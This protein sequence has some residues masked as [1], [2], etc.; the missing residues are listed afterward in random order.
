MGYMKLGQNRPGWYANPTDE[1]MPIGAHSTPDMAPD[2]RDTFWDWYAEN[3]EVVSDVA[4]D[5]MCL[6]F[7]NRCRQQ[8]PFGYPGPTPPPEKDYTLYLILG[9]V[10]ILLFVLILRKS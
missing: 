1:E 3:G 6:L 8:P 4:N 7:P 2:E 10:V 5:A 9:V